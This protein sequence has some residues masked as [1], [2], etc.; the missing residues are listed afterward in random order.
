MFH[1]VLFNEYPSFMFCDYLLLQNCLLANYLFGENVCHENVCGI[2]L[3]AKILDRGI[4]GHRADHEGW[5]DY[6]CNLEIVKICY[7]GRSMKLSLITNC[8]GNW[9][10]ELTSEWPWEP[11]HWAC[12]WGPV[13]TEDRGSFPN[14]LSGVKH[15]RLFQQHRG[16]GNLLPTTYDLEFLGSQVDDIWGRFII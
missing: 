9:A 12:Q 6:Q 4:M 11:G 8:Q 16:E 10:Y 13:C 7:L 14:V 5:W 3:M 1:Y 2:M 15:L